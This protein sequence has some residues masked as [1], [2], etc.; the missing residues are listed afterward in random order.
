MKNSNAKFK[1]ILPESENEPIL[2]SLPM[3]EIIGRLEHEI[4]KPKLSP[5]KFDESSK[6]LIK[7]K[8]PLLKW[9]GAI[10]K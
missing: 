6:H 4:I 2:D 3:S 5:P 7:F 8:N 10:T 1:V 9:M